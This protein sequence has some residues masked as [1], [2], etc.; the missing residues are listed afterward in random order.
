MSA[1]AGVRGGDE[2]KVTGKRIGAVH[3]HDSH[4]VL[5]YR[6]SER[7]EDV[8]LELGELVEEEDPPVRERDLTRH[9]GTTTSHEPSHRD[10]VVRCPERPPS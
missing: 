9:H 8:G 5:L 7:L 1:R 3:P 4:L 2:L 6:L 10:G